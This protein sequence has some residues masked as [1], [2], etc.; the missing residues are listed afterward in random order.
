M[1]SSLIDDPYLD[2]SRHVGGFGAVVASAGF[3]GQQEAEQVN[4]ICRQD[5]GG[6]LS[7]CPYP[8]LKQT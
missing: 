1:L 5:A 6:K 3:A 2:F 4:I 8:Y 7:V